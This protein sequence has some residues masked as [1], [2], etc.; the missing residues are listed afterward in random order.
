[1]RLSDPIPALPVAAIDAALD[2][3]TT[4]FGFTVPH[5][6]GGFAI[7]NRDDVYL[8]L[9]EASDTG[10][11]LRDPEDLK[12]QPVRTG[13]EDFIAGTASCRIL[14]DEVDALYSELAAKG[15]L[16]PTDRGEPEDTDYG[17]REFATLDLD[18]N[19]L[20]FYR[21]T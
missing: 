21:W 10:W 17:T 9:W 16:H 1:M 2:Y 20:T 13:A 14:V 4:R 12:E 6:D 15:V 5:H 11:R 18:G 3:Y 8:H 19:L 7:V